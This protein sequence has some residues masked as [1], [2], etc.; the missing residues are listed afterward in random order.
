MRAIGLAEADA[1][2]QAIIAV[3]AAT[4][5]RVPIRIRSLSR[6]TDPSKTDRNPFCNAN[7]RTDAELRDWRE[8][9]GRSF[10]ADK[11]S[12]D[13]RGDWKKKASARIREIE[14]S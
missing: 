9:R 1:K 11:L 8:K 10:P 3:I 6:L 4:A 14:K 13:S 7:T 2:P 12:T 5:N